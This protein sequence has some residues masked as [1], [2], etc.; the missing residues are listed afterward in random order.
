M[1]PQVGEPS[2]PAAIQYFLLWWGAATA[3][4]ALAALVRSGW[5]R[6]PGRR[7]VLEGKLRKVIA[8]GQLSH[9]VSIFGPAQ[10]VEPWHVHQHGEAVD[11]DVHSWVD[12]DHALRLWVVGGQ[13]RSWLVT[14]RSKRF[15]P[16]WRIGNLDITLNRTLLSEVELGDVAFM[17]GANWFGYAETIHLG[18]GA[19]YQHVTVGVSEHALLTRES[20]MMKVMQDTDESE[21]DEARAAR[22]GTARRQ[23]CPDTIAA[24]LEGVP[25]VDPLR[26]P[27]STAELGRLQPP[28]EWTP[29]ALQRDRARDAT[30]EDT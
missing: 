21:S 11:Y 24:H 26:L 7:R 9:V 10:F 6:G 1:L 2:L 23:T 18:R 15:K 12:D 17:V 5:R 29:R 22:I 14:A 28:V 20:A 30:K 8:G 27:M 4:L 3:A 13:V 25:A 16:R 19:W